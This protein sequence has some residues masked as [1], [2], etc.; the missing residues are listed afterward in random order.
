MSENDYITATFDQLVVDARHSTRG[1]L[2]DAIEAI[3][4]A[5]GPGYAKS[6]PEL[7]SAYIQACAHDFANATLSKVA[8]NA[9]RDLADAG[10]WPEL[11]VTQ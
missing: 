4:S 11:T 8:G 1:H 2:R 9:L 6:H 10:R 7:V 3:D 5:F